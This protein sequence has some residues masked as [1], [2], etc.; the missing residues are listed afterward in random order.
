[1]TRIVIAALVGIWLFNFIKF[2]ASGPQ[3]F[4]PDQEAI[5]ASGRTQ[6]M[7]TLPADAAIAIQPEQPGQDGTRRIGLMLAEPAIVDIGVYDGSGRLVRGQDGK[8][9]PAGASVVDLPVSNLPSG[10]YWVRARTGDQ[11]ATAFVAVG[12]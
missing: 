8:R 3:P 4:E 6:T 7:Q 1:M 9:L 10:D 5:A 12:H 11:I 2:I